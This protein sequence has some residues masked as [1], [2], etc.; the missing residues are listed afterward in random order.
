MTTKE[1]ATWFSKLDG[2]TI[3]SIEEDKLFFYLKNESLVVKIT[4]VANDSDNFF[5]IA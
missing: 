1:F 3:I 5:I 2:L 4:Q